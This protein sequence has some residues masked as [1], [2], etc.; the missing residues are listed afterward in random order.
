MPTISSVKHT[1]PISEAPEAPKVPKASLTAPPLPPENFV[2]PRPGLLVTVEL[3]KANEE[4]KSKVGCIVKECRAKNRK[5][6]DIEFDLETDQYRCLHGLD[7]PHTGMYRPSDVQRV[8]QIIDKPHFFVKEADSND[9]IQ[10][11]LGDCWFLSA[12]ATVSTAK[13]LVDKFCVARD[14][15]VGVYG[16]IFFRDN[17]WVNVVVDE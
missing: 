3:E 5:F 14:E 2:Q 4:C 1:A 6:R 17:R 10:G 15:E 16:F 11:K 13:G 12:L 9:I 8:M 7:Y